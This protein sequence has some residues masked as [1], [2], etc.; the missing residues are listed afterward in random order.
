MRILVVTHGGGSPYHGPNMRWY[1]LGRALQEKDAHVGIV[2][3]S[4]FHKYFNQ[5]FVPSLTKKEVIDGVSYHW[6]KTNKYSGRFFQVLNQIFFSVMAFF[7]LP[8]IVRAG[9]YDV[10]V[11]SSPHPLIVYAAKRC[12]KVV[13]IPW[14]YEVRD[15]WPLV[16]QQ[17]SGASDKNPYIRLL[18]FTER[19]AVRNADSVVSVK[20]GDGEYFHEQYG[21]PASRFYYVPNGFFPSPGSQNSEHKPQDDFVVGYVGAL[22]TY[23]CIDD[24]IEAAKE[25][26]GER[27][28]RFRV[29]GGGEDYGRLKELVSYYGLSNVS[30]SGKVTRAQVSK[31][32]SMFDVCYVGLKNVDANLYGISCN[33]IFEYMYASKPIISN[34]RSNYDPVKMASC[35][36]SVFPGSSSEI[37]EAVRNMREN[38]SIAAEMGKKGREY[39]DANHDFRLIS[40]VYMKVIQDVLSGPSND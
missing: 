17:L 15:L 26:S 16:I 12:S 7:L 13:N 21:L 9:N 6:I 35:G 34:Y 37:A 18:S 19:Y 33:K 31:E 22:S 11:A 4:F 29:V 28:I 40:D 36:V 1:Y 2:S 14:I 32:L 30:F 10:V 38:P 39:F 8:G 27:G 5:P 24:L 3:S 23:Y 25:L 20:P